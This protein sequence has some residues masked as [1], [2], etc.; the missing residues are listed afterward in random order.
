MAA[1]I[2]IID[3]TPSG[4]VLQRTKLVLAS[5]KISARELIERRVRDEVARFNADAGVLTFRG[6]VAPL[7]AEREQSGYRLRQR[8]LLDADAQC[9][10]ALEQFTRNGFFMLADDRQIESL[11]EEIVVTPTST[12]SFVKLV[13]LVGG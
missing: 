6:L 3:E 9:A 7:D 8:R 4:E 11:D 10:L 13:P 1:E 2:W 12:V 5:E